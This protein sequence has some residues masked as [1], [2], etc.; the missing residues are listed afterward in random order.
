MWSFWLWVN[1]AYPRSRAACSPRALR[2]SVVP[3]APNHKTWFGLW[4]HRFVD[5]FQRFGCLQSLLLNSLFFVTKFSLILGAFTAIV[6]SS[7]V[8]SLI[9]GSHSSG[10][11]WMTIYRSLGANYICFLKLVASVSHCR[12]PTGRWG[13]S[14]NV[15]IFRV[16]P[17]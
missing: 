4:C 17:Y 9:T 15:R 1:S 7:R 12:Y 11:A 5:F 2:P 6:N 16:C 13:K 8:Q 3:V 10:Q 14:S